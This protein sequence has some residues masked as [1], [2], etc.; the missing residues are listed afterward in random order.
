MWPSFDHFISDVAKRVALAAAGRFSG[1]RYYSTNTED[2]R[3]DGS[4]WVSVVIEI[5]PIPPTRI[6]ARSALSERVSAK[7]ADSSTNRLQ[8]LPAPSLAPTQSTTGSLQIPTTLL[9]LGGTGPGLD[10]ACTFVHEAC[11]I[12]LAAAESAVH[13]A[14]A[15]VFPML[16]LASSPH[17]IHSF[18]YPGT[19][20]PA[21]YDVAHWVASVVQPLLPVPPLPS[22][23]ASEKS[24]LARSFKVPKQPES[25]PRYRIPIE[26]VS[27]GCLVP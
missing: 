4:H 21:A 20:L 22:S 16:L 5:I 12:V 1:R 6:D 24:D 19:L 15:T 10:S 25:A 14:L 8:P 17:F 9:P 18:G 13:L 26:L 11:G 3:S 2:S 27:S 23:W 7:E